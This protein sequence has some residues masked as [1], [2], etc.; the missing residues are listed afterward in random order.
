MEGREREIEG[1]EGQME[2]R[3]RDWGGEGEMEGREREMG[4]GEGED[5]NTLTHEDDR[6]IV[7]C[8]LYT[9]I[10]SCIVFCHTVGGMGKSYGVGCVLLNLISM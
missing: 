7:S 9:V 6:K 8:V 4:G 1:G 3:E 10:R 2:G 5:G